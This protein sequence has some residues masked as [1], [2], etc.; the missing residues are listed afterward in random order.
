M[1]QLVAQGNGRDDFLTRVDE[2][3]ELIAEGQNGRLIIETDRRFSPEELTDLRD[4]IEQEGVTIFDVCQNDQLLVVDFQKNLWPL[5]II[6][7]L[8]LIPIA[9][10][11]WKLMLQS[12]ETTFTQLLKYIVIPIGVL[13]I[14]GTVLY[15]SLR[16]PGDTAKAGVQGY[17]VQVGGSF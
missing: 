4:K 9:G 11:G 10:F 14:V 13:A 8:L 15:M 17:G 3:E 5:L 1:L 16:K 6:G 2:L 12:T 7:G